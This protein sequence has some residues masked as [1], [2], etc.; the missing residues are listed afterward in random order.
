MCDSA[1][2][3]KAMHSTAHSVTTVTARPH[4]S[5]GSD[6]VSSMAESEN[7]DSETVESLMKLVKDQYKKIRALEAQLAEAGLESKPVRPPQ[8][9]PQPQSICES[10]PATDNLQEDQDNPGVFYCQVCWN[11]YDDEVDPQSPHPEGMDDGDNILKLRPPAST[12][13]AANQMQHISPYPEDLISPLASYTNPPPNGKALPRTPPGGELPIPCDSV[14]RR[15]PPQKVLEVHDTPESSTRLWIMHNNPKLESELQL[16]EINVEC[17]VETKDPTHARCGRVVVG[18]ITYCGPIPGGYC[19]PDDATSI[20]EGSHCICLEDL[21]AYIL[22]YEDIETRLSISGGGMDLKLDPKLETPLFREEYPAGPKDFLKG[23]SG[24]VS[25]I[26]DPTT[27]QGGWYPYKDEDGNSIPRQFRSNGKGSIKLGDDMSQNGLCFLSNDECRSFFL[28]SGAKVRPNN[29]RTASC[30]DKGH[31]KTASNSISRLEK[32][33]QQV[34]AAVAAPRNNNLNPTFDAEVDDDESCT[35]KESDASKEDRKFSEITL[36]ENIENLEQRGS[37]N[38]KGQ[39]DWQETKA[40]LLSVSSAIVQDFLNEDLPYINDVLR[41]TADLIQKDKNS[42]V[43]RAAIEAAGEIGSKLKRN[44]SSISARILVSNLLGV[45]GDKQLHEQAKNLLDELHG[46]WFTLS[47]AMGGV[48]T[49]ILK[50]NR[51]QGATAVNIMEWLSTALALEMEDVG[52]FKPML[53]DTS[54]K[55]VIK[56][57]LEFAFHRDENCRRG[58]Q[59]SLA[60]AMQY[61]VCHLK[62]KETYVV[63][64]FKPLHSSRNAAQKNAWKVILIKAK[65]KTG[66]KYFKNF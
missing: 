43:R 20:S 60:N 48:I 61:G 44:L 38:K 29:T 15:I 1:G 11:A 10:C 26:L 21:R 22:N 25:V 62:M 8:P 17:W 66:S 64:Q 50:N 28:A 7:A 12:I 5:R 57:L 59:N 54:L 16:G 9:Q 36:K 49:D 35:S 58:V 6:L 23:C 56:C 31:I 51:S 27:F 2:H 40:A 13:I 4:N 24:C 52:K 33:Q 14:T 39:L 46:R 3:R 37:D 45:L 47:T 65:T 53:D 19:K 30:G 42:Q 41:I 32:T 55:A 18:T 63:D 34:A